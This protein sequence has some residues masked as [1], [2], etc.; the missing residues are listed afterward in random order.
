MM[1]F[2][3]RDPAGEENPEQCKEKPIIMMTAM[4]M[5][6]TMVTIECRKS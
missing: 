6:M 3:E 2:E 4:K 5:M 1:Q